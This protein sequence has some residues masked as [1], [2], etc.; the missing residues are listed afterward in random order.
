M[1]LSAKGLLVVVLGASAIAATMSLGFWQVRRGA[2]KQSMQERVDDAMRAAPIAPSRAQWNAPATLVGRHVTVTGRWL[3]DRT[4]YLDNRPMQGRQ[5][6]FVLMALRVEGPS[7][8]T[9]VVNRGWIPRDASERTRIAPYRTATGE[10]TVTGIVLADEPRLLDI[11]SAPDRAL[12]GLWQNFEFDD[13]RRLSGEPVVALV[14]RQDR[15]SAPAD[16]LDRDWPDR[17]V[18]LQAQIDRHHGYAFQWF[19]LAATLAA[20]LL[21]HFLRMIRP[22]RVLHR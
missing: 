4:V 15:E 6:L 11:G 3:P 2:E 21:Y 1:S 18:A 19:A 16:D 9:I 8:L 10:V 12:S 14:V 7:P 20:L 5:G 13:F 22:A 17:G